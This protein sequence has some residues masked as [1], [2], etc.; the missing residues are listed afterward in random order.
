M[1]FQDI[2]EQKLFLKYF[3]HIDTETI[4]REITQSNAFIK[5]QNARNPE[6]TGHILDNLFHSIFL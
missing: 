2:F 3:F 4:C 5:Y 6:P 1:K